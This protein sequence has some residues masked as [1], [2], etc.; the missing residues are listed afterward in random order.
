MGVLLSFG[1]AFE[2]GA[3]GLEQRQVLGLEGVGHG[4]QGPWSLI[5]LPGV[6]QLLDGDRGDQ[7]GHDQAAQRRFRL[8]EHALDVEA[9]GLL[10]SEQLLDGPAAAV[11]AGHGPRPPRRW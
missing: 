3:E 1:L 9:V 8:D 10:G 11:E 7:V 6:D 4:A 5:V 2:L